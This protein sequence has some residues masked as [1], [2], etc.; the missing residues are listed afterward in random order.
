M[1]T[2]ASLANCY[3]TG[4]KVIDTANENVSFARSAGS[5]QSLL[6]EEAVREDVVCT[7]DLFR[8]RHEDRCPVRII[9]S[10]YD[11]DAYV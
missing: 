3:C 8:N 7:M 10:I 4:N 2:L 11:Y 5:L 1:M 9:I 6:H